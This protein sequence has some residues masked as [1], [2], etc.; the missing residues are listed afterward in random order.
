M[1]MAQIKR[2][3][4]RAAVFFLVGALT[5]LPVSAFASPSSGPIGDDL[6]G[7]DSQYQAKDDDKS[8]DDRSKDG[9]SKDGKSKDDKSKDDK[10]K[11][12]KSK[13]DKCKDDDKGKY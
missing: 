9:K 6:V 1:V 11:D 10:S 8:K 2:R 12:D 7:F 3:L 13:D 4:G 5:L